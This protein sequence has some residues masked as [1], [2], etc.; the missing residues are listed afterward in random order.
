MKVKI[1]GIG[2]TKFGEH[3]QKSLVDLAEEAGM[4]AVQNAGLNLKNLDAIFVGNMLSASV[5]GQEHLGALVAERLNLKI[6]AIRIEGACASGA[7]AINQACLAIASGHYQKVLVIGVEKM[8]D[9]STAAV[10]QALMGASAEAEEGI[11]GFTF[12]SLYA[13]MARAYM[14]KYGLKE[15]ELAQVSV[16][17]H[18]HASLNPL[19]QFPFKVSLKQVLESPMV[20]DPLKV[21]DCSPITDGAAAIVLSRRPL[22]VDHRQISVS[23]IGSSLV[24]DTLSLSARKEIIEQEATIKA[25]HEALQMAGIKLK[26]IDLAEVHDCFTIAEIIGLES[27]GFF[28]KGEAGRATTKGMT[29]YNGV[30]PVNTSGGLKA[31][32]HPV[33]ATGV[34]QIV[35]IVLQLRGQAGK[36]QV[37]NA[38]IG[39]AQNIGGS[40]STAVVHIL[41]RENHVL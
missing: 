17:N 31:C 36:R 1:I 39:L 14:E 33:G 18:A 9:L 11:N 19:A 27:L 12:A 41:K 30:L 32:G 22:T 16:K 5:T 8:T 28:K 29:R 3:W 38:R 10:N 26:E 15:E 4:K 23:I 24:S 21:L 6:P 25:V 35:E 34:K 40:G 7:M 13:L 37:K 20:A 2:M